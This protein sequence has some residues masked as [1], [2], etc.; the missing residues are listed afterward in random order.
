MNRCPHCQCTEF[1]KQ[2]KTYIDNTGLG[3]K[4]YYCENPTT[5]EYKCH[6]WYIGG[7]EKLI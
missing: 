1:V 4:K 6:P 7:E 2:D 3:L 5:K